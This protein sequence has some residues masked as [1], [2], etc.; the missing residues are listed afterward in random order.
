MFYFIADVIDPGD[1]TRCVFMTVVFAVFAFLA[2]GLIFAVPYLRGKPTKRRCACA[3][4]EEAT[5]VLDERERAKKD[6]LRYDPNTVDANDLP[7][8]SPE[9]AQYESRR[10]S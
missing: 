9:L 6:A 5:R 1:Q 2:F 3:A 10:S 8:V 4:S 7:T